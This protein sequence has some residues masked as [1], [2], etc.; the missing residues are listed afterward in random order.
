M[1]DDV[2]QLDELLATLDRTGPVPLY[3]Q[4]SS[5]IERAIRSGDIAPGARLENEIAIAQRLGLSRPTIR[6]AM[7]ELVDKGLLVRRRGIGTQ[8]V[9]GQVT[10][11]VELTSLYEDLQSSHHAPGTR[12]LEH[13]IRPADAATAAALSVPAGSDVVYLRRQ[14]STDGVPVAV[15]VNYLP[16]DFAD[17]TTE[18]LEAKGLYQIM[19]ARGVTIRVAN[20]RIGARRAQGDEGELLDIDKG[21]PVLTME[22]VAYDASGRA[23]EFG[24]HCYRPDMYSF[25]TTLVAK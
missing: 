8:V 4:V 24:H 20:Q 21:G 3:F 6:R 25:E 7:E 22:R 9:Q 10:R 19:R 12:V 23:V 17:I 18:Q 15:L 1:A 11:Q 16:P 5:A 13:E 14:R 2:V